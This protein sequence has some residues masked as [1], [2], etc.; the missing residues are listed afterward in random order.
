MFYILRGRAIFECEGVEREVGA[1]DCAVIPE[2]QI[3]RQYNPFD[4]SVEWVYF[5]VATD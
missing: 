5:G 2:G 3:H 1:G 4:H